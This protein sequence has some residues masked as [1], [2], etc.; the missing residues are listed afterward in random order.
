MIVGKEDVRR[1]KPDPE[2]LASIARA[3]ATTP[4]DMLF[5]G[6]TDFDRDAGHAFGVR[7]VILDTKEADLP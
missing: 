1:G 2:G 4:G 3:L 7:T 6:D 5:I